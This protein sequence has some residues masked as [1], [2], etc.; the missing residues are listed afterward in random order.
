MTPWAIE[1]WLTP[2]HI[3][4]LL[5]SPGP[6]PCNGWSVVK[7]QAPG[8]N[9][10]L[11]FTNQTSDN[12]DPEWVQSDLLD[13]STGG[14]CVLLDLSCGGL[15]LLVHHQQDPESL[16]MAPGTPLTVKL[17]TDPSNSSES[18]EPPQPSDQKRRRMLVPLPKRWTLHAGTPLQRDPE[19]IARHAV[20]LNVAN[21]SV[22][23]ITGFELGRRF[24]E[25]TFPDAAILLFGEFRAVGYRS[26]LQFELW[27]SR[28]AFCGGL[29][30]CSDLSRGWSGTGQHRI[31]SS[32]HRRQGL[33]LQVDRFTRNPT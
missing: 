31:G 23:G 14:A 22:T 19:P 7:P 2:Q 1:P 18:T 8:V 10:K 25:G 20:G 12:L 9:I 17:Q 16:A 15:S 28:L 30:R 32:L 11:D 27:N 24:G 21:N 3:T 29:R 33:F 13:I 26:R 5:P 6:R 4:L